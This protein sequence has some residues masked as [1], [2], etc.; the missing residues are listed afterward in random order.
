M[1]HLDTNYLIRVL[2]RDS[3]EAAR[4]DEWLTGGESF[5]ASAVAWTE[6]L[7]GPVTAAEIT[8]AEALI[9]ARIIPFGKFEAALASELFNKTGRRRGSRLDCLIAATAIIAQAQLATA[10]D[11]DFRPFVAHGLA[12]AAQA[13]S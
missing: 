9:G 5:S 7:S 3:P 2:V 10:N 6:F 12:L 11:A 8:N 13:Q 4:V 1:I